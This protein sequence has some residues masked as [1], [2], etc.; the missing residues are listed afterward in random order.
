MQAYNLPFY[1]WEKTTPNKPFLRQPKGDKWEVYT[2]AET[3]QLARKLATGLQSLGLPPKSH[4][5]LVSKNCRE[6]IIADVAIMMAG[7]VSVPFYPT[8]GAVA[9]AELI[10]IGDVKALFAGKVEDWDGMKDGVP[11]ETP[12]ISFPQYPGCSKI[13]EGEEFYSFLNRFKPMTGEPCPDLDD[14]W[15]MVFTSGTTGTPKGVVHDYR[16]L[17]STEQVTIQNNHLHISFEG[18]NHFFSFLP[19]N[20]IAERVLVECSALRFG[21]TISF[22]ESL[23]TFTKNLQESQPTFFFAVPRIWTKFQLG[24]LSKM[25]QAHLDAALASPQAEMVKKKLRLSLGM[26]KTRGC[27]TGAASIPE[28]LKEWYRKLDVPIAEGYG[29]TENCAMATCLK[30]TEIIPGSVGKALPGVTLKIDEETSEIM[31]KAP[32]VMRGYYKDPEKTAETITKDGFLRTGDQGYIDEDGY[33]FITGRVKDTFKTGK[34]KF[35]IPS[36]I[37]CH[38]GHDVNIE[39][40]C[41]VGLGCP[42]PLALIV[43]SEIGLSKSKKELKSSYETTLKVV[44]EKLPNYQKV[45]TIVIVKDTWSLENGLLT[46]TMKVKRH[47]M[48]K[49]YNDLLLAWHEHEDMVIWE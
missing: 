46:P 19:L 12:I 22:A 17:E 28:V 21:G 15:T 30:H 7:F 39:Q 43:P 40:I 49:R 27:L 35:I 3:G 25:P 14:I 37:E 23:T 31:T 29:M 26:D 32:F 9:V 38:F 8:L 45:S 24:V 6:W 18:D 16:I 47:I 34:G 33:L 10:E 42:Q 13:E 20:H 1:H 48:G 41:I 11:K 4:I 36:P 44:N 2:W 5:G